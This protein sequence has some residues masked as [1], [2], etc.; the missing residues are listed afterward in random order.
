M[1]RRP[2]KRELEAENAGLRKSW[3]D[4]ERRLAEAV[5]DAKALADAWKNCPANEHQDS[6]QC[7]RCPVARRIESK[8]GGVH[9]GVQP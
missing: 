8:W 6:C 5:A 7:H 9:S 1:S 4:A 3:E 2:Y